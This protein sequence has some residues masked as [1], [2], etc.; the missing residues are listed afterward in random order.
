MGI[1]FDCPVGVGKGAFEVS[2]VAANLS[3]V[4]VDL[5]AARVQGY[6][7]IEV[8]ECCFA[9]PLR[10]PRDLASPEAQRLKVAILRELG[11]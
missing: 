6:P 1:E 11:L 8:G 2:C 4:T 3:T 9:V 10:H 5:S 7:L